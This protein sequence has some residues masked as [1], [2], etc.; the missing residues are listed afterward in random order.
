MKTKFFLIGSA[1]LLAAATGATA[2]D[3]VVMIEP[4]TASYV[5]ACDAFGSGYF[6]IPGTETCLDIGGYVRFET[7]FGGIQTGSAADGDWY[8]YV[9]T[10]LA[11]TAKSDTELGTLTSKFVPE[12]Y[13]YSNGTGD[14]FTI[15]EAYI[16][17]GD[18]LALR[19]GY[20]KGYW[21]EDLWGELDNID[22]VS[23]YNAIRI[24][25][26]GA[27]H[28][29]AAL[30]IDAMTPGNVGLSDTNYP[31]L[32]L[33]ARLGYIVS[34]S[35]YFK[36]DAAWDT[37][38][39]T[40]A[41]RPWAG[42]GIGPGTFEI[43]GLYESGFIAYGPDFTAANWNDS[44]IAGTY[45]KYAV[46]ANYYFNVTENLILAPQTQYNVASNDKA[47]WE[48]GATADWEIVDDFHLRTNINYAFLDD[49]WNQQNWFGWVRLERD[50]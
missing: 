21:N 16:D 1:S 2:A 14:D 23:R 7:K 33:A 12:L 22:N 46:A 48:A 15:D 25:Y 3:P 40:Y 49:S 29:Q 26:N 36:F 17:I 45:L 43:A 32:G 47:F 39:E 11:I 44:P 6:Y 9:K 42:F 31:K 24:A 19:A 8:P 27:D 18:A 50:F 30:E 13:F 34:D 20:I 38:N 10:N 28:F 4:V 37:Y 35:N 41:L 5:E